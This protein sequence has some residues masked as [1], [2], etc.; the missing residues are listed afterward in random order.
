MVLDQLESAAFS[1]A[2]ASTQGKLLIL[3]CLNSIISSILFESS[4][5]NSPFQSVVMADRMAQFLPALFSC[6]AKLVLK[7][8]V[9]ENHK[10][11]VACYHLMGMVVST[12]LK[13]DLCTTFLS[14]PLS[15]FMLDTSSALD[16]EAKS[17]PPQPPMPA[18]PASNDSPY[19]LLNRD[20][21]W[22][23]ATFFN[24]SK[25]LPSLLLFISHDLWK[26]RLAVLRMVVVLL[27][28]CNRYLSLVL[29]SLYLFFSNYNDINVA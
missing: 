23:K 27:K 15:R 14:S 19:T 20:E 29:S 11:I 25:A 18:P 3:N 22:L 26:V 4:A 12:C 17:L 16:P 2:A 1:D 9:N 6:L 28:N 21:A 8:S 7:R 24:I 13:D 5:L 10:V